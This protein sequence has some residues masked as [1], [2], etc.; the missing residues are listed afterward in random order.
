MWYGVFFS[1]ATVTRVLINAGII[2]GNAGWRNLEIW[3]ASSP[4][5]PPGQA[6]VVLHDG[7]PNVS[8]AWDKDAYVQ[9]VLVLTACKLACEFLVKG[10]VFVTKVFRSS[11]YPKLMFVLKELFEKVRSLAVPLLII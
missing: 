2:G 4:L 9:N 5:A 8:G 11:D 3:D 6:D 7:A 10:G 1:V